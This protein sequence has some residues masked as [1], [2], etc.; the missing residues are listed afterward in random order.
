[1]KN[2]VHL[3]FALLS[4]PLFAQEAQTNSVSLKHIMG[5]HAI[6]AG[7][8]FTKHGSGPAISYIYY[9]TNKD[10]F[11]MGL[12]SE[13]GKIGLTKFTNYGARLVYN[14]TLGNAEEVVFLNFGG[15]LK[16]GVESYTN[17]YLKIDESVFYYGGLVN[18]TI[19]I[20]FSKRLGVV[21][22]ADQNYILN[23]K[24]GELNWQLGGTIR[25]TF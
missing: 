13:I 14:R 16:T 5:Q 20:L 7:Y 24:L 3:I 11:D 22:K 1:M 12:N 6:D 9:K 18:C 2:F 8:N 25:Y 23:S 19:E 17:E 15:G 4:V 10:V 21:L